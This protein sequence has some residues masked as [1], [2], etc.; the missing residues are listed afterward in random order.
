MDEGFYDAVGIKSCFHTTMLLI[1]PVL[2]PTCKLMLL[3]QPVLDPCNHEIYNQ[4]SVY[5]SL[6]GVTAAEQ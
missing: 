6:A 2:D 3:I 1:P 5:L 4:W